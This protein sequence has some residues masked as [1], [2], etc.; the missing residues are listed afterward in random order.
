[1]LHVYTH[2]ISDVNKAN[3]LQSIK[4]EG[5]KSFYHTHTPLKYKT[6]I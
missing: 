1:M 2:N 3:S 5:K 6:Q 4:L